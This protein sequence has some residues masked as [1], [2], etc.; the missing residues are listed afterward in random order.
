[1]SGTKTGIEYRSTVPSMLGRYTGTN[2]W[3]FHDK[4]EQDMFFNP[5]DAKEPWIL[6]STGK[7]ATQTS[8]MDVDRDRYT[9]DLNYRDTCFLQEHVGHGINVEPDV[10]AAGGFHPFYRWVE[11][12]KARNYTDGESMLIDL[13][14][15]QVPTF[16][17]LPVPDTDIHPYNNVTITKPRIF[18]GVTD[19]SSRSSYQ[20]PVITQ[21][22]S[23]ID[24]NS[25]GLEFPS[26]ND[27]LTFSEP[28]RQQHDRTTEHFG[29]IPF[30][31]KNHKQSYDARILSGLSNEHPFTH[32]N[33]QSNREQ[34][35]S[36]VTFA[37][38]ASIGSIG[39]QKG[40]LTDTINTHKTN[41]RI[42]TST[43]SSFPYQFTHERDNSNA[44]VSISERS[45]KN[46]D[47]QYEDVTLSHK[48]T[49]LN[50]NLN[51]RPNQQTRTKRDD[52]NVALLNTNQRVLK[53]V[54]SNQL[55]VNYKQSKKQEQ[56]IPLSVIEM[57]NYTHTKTLPV[58][59]RILEEAR[60]S[61]FDTT[62]K[63]SIV[64][65][66]TDTTQQTLPHMFSQRETPF[67][68]E[69]TVM[70]GREAHK[71]STQMTLPNIEKTSVKKNVLPVPIGI[72]T[73]T[74]QAPITY[75]NVETNR[76]IKG[77]QLSNGI[78]YT[79]G[80]VLK[81]LPSA[82][83][84]LPLTTL[85]HT[86]KEMNIEHRFPN[87]DIRPSTF[88]TRDN[89]RS[90]FESMS[91]STLRDGTATVTTPSYPGIPSYAVGTLQERR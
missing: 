13:P 21:Q 44:P 36:R 27:V 42:T 70:G 55:P 66:Q 82:G 76:S 46:K 91:M 62:N 5:I 88:D 53:L 38:D 64:P 81:R 2:D 40:Y 20:V 51:E 9:M 60:V 78:A 65:K 8:L 80:A 3:S 34:D 84:D 22:T 87:S 6:G 12:E 49:I 73:N 63:S 17:L 90:F 35:R 11:D 23:V 71:T 1:M 56:E 43:A 41:N 86:K 59:T 19:T 30:L 26:K 28:I 57:H 32:R 18:D 33:T 25:A 54:D 10:P 69:N 16:P 48:R 4:Q 50:N 74:T 24:I 15:M 31:S 75:T 7:G 68:F 83:H 85:P 67:V 37:A 61:V 77:K 29:N 45:I 89:G 72:L 58:S 39:Y 47:Q 79:P 52:T 14:E